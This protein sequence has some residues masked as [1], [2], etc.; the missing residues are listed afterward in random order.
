MKRIHQL[1]LVSAFSLLLFAP[2]RSSLQDAQDDFAITRPGQS[3]LVDVLGNDGALGGDLRL[4]KAFKPA[5]GSVAIEDGRIRYTPAAGFQGSDSFRYMVQSAKSQPGQATV[6][7]EVGQGGVTLRLAGRVVDDPIPGATVTVSVGG[8]DFVTTADA[9]GNYVLDIAA[10]RGDAF[11]TIEA[12]G[13]SETGAS[14]RF[15]SLA[16]EILLVK[17]GEKAAERETPPKFGFASLIREIVRER[18]LFRDI[19]V[20]AAMM[21]VFALAPALFWQLII[22]RVLVYKSISTFQILVGGMAFVYCG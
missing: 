15:Y 1:M 22:D 18:R 9:N 4:L 8:F 14:V 10:L 12:T 17:K 3:V 6:N 7:V 20:A 11:V 13:T 19:A 2:A 16:G 21:A 5:H